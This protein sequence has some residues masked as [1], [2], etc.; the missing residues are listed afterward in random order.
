MTEL[1][2]SPPPEFPVTWRCPAEENLLWCHDQTHYPDQITPLEFSL[3]GQGV[4]RGL[5]KA[6]RAYDIPITVHVRHINGYLYVAIERDE[7]QAPESATPGPGLSDKL[8]SAMAGLRTSWETTWLPEI[9]RH[10]SWWAT[11]DRTTAAIPT[12]RQHLA[13]TLH[14]WQRLWELHF[15]L[16]VPS[17][18]A[19]SEFAD[20]YTDLSG[21]GNQFAAFQLLSG[22]PSKTLE[23]AQQL[24]ALS[25]QILA[26]PAVLQVFVG[27]SSADVIKQLTN[28]ADCAPFLSG[29]H[30]YLDV[31][32]ERA[33]RLTLRDPYW[34]DDPTPVI[35]TLRNYIQRPHKNLLAEMQDVARQRELLTS[36]FC[37]DIQYYPQPLR[38]QALFFLHAAQAGAFLSAEHG[39]WIDYK[40]SYRVR[41]VLL[42]IGDRLEAAG[43]LVDKDDLFYLH[44]DEVVELF[45]RDGSAGRCNAEYLEQVKIRRAQ[46]ERF[47]DVSPTP[48]LGTVPHGSAD[49]ARDPIT[50]MFRKWEGDVPTRTETGNLLVGTAG[51]PGVVRGT[52]KVVHQLSAAT[53]VQPGDIL[54][55]DTT[56][57]PWTPLFATVGGLVTDSGGV[58]SHSAVVAREYGIPAVVGAGIATQRLQDGQ[59][60]EVDGTRGT[61]LILK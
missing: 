26:T 16:V 57:P 25:R 41:Q 45:D 23:N 50:E 7:L 20:L 48:L 35:N 12:L 49:D 61:V 19:M 55:A 8:R 54:V 11:F 56:S 14:R 31:H 5:A 17:T 4:H 24:W 34:C 32:G 59:R 33:D 18:F 29:L 27:K 38:D 58:L 37:A 43:T 21:D 39:Y 22:F 44:L 13:E 46:A 2:S 1:T 51:S 52:V 53:K 15:L 28:C 40:A 60:V 10:L 6:V 36:K 47:A 30:Q 9:K 42:T 3:L